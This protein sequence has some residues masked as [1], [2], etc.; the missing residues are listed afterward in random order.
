MIHFQTIIAVH[1]QQGRT[2]TDKAAALN[3]M[4][5]THVLPV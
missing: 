4:P 3:T 2:I 5:W 1:F